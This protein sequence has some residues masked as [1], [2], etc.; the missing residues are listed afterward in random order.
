MT[1][2]SISGRPL[3]VAVA[4]L[5]A[6]C[7]SGSAQSYTNAASVSDAAGRWCAGGG[8]SNINATAQSGGITWG[9]PVVAD[10]VGDTGAYGSLRVV[11]GNPAIA[12]LDLTNW[13]LK[14]VRANDA[15]GVAWGTPTAACPPS[16]GVN[17]GIR[18]LVVSN[19]PVIAYDNG[20]KEELQV[21]RMVSM[22]VYI[23]WIAVEP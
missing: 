19:M 1:C 15:N 5:L 7:G 11:N 21:V 8:Y 13:D 22:P 12:Y 3:P 17:G 16:E 23:N 4:I 9:T 18:M 10:S 14:Y 6:C 20:G 2:R